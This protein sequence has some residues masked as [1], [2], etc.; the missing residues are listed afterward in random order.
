MWLLLQQ[1]WRLL[2]QSLASGSIALTPE[3]VNAL[4]SMEL[5]KTLKSQPKKSKSPGRSEDPDCS[6]SS[7]ESSSS[8]GKK[9]GAS[10]AMRS[11]RRGHRSMR[12]NP[13]RHV[14]RYIREV[15]ECLGATRD[16]PYQLSDY[17]RRLNWGKQKTLLR[18][19]FAISEALQTLLRNQT[20]LA[21]LELVQILRAVHQ[22]CLDNGSWKASWLL[23]RY[24]DPVDVPRFGGEP[25]ELE[26]VAAYMDALQKLKKRSKG[27]S[28]GDQE[29]D[30]AKGKRGK[31]N[32]KKKNDE[33]KED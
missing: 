15:E 24:Q 23:L 12:K 6:D 29:D 7:L 2:Q 1:A 22:T 8:H 11:Y 16:T 13:G 14:R 20:E 10:R 17:T 3:N 27:I 18:I 4:I 5:L 26:R 9:G 32:A 28:K 25:Q 30:A 31:G 33:A 21:A 19:H